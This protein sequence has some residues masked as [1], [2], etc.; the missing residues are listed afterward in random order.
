MGGGE[1]MKG[2]GFKKRRGS[3]KKGGNTDLKVKI[4]LVYLGVSSCIS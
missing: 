2:G 4:M 3:F 1:K